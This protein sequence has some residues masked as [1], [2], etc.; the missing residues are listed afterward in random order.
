MR[1]LHVGIILVCSAFLI[2]ITMLIS[3]LIAALGHGLIGGRSR[4]GREPIPKR[5]AEPLHDAGSAWVPHGS[6]SIAPRAKKNTGFRQTLCCSRVLAL[7]E[8]RTELME[9]TAYLAHPRA[10]GAHSFGRRAC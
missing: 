4:G 6:R 1:A 7:R 5:G 2:V 10:N 9:A 8:S 3:N